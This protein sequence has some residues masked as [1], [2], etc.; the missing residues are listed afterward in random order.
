MI[1]R[2]T[3][4]RTRA[5]RPLTAHL[6]QIGEVT[7]AT[8]VLGRRQPEFFQTVHI[9]VGQALGLDLLPGT[10]GPVDDLG[11]ADHL[12]T[13]V[14]QALYRGQHRASRGGGVL[15]REHLAA[16]DVRAL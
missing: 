11:D 15:H 5:I 10:G 8:L 13:D 16:R 2:T 7:A 3:R 9:T 4:T 1:T 12:G 14:A 6:P